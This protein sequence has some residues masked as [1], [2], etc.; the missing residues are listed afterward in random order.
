MRASFGG[1]W[2][3]CAGGEE[4]DGV[5]AHAESVDRNAPRVSCWLLVIPLVL[6]GKMLSCSFTCLNLAISPEIGW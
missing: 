1:K 4:K 3:D 6:G 2:S 5:L